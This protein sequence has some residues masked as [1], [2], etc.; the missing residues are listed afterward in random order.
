MFPP[1]I[2][3]VPPPS[4]VPGTL[5]LLT[6]AV[7]SSY[8]WP[9]T[10]LTIRPQACLVGSTATPA[11]SEEPNEATEPDDATADATCCAKIGAK[12]EKT[13]IAESS[14]TAHE[15]PDMRSTLLVPY[16]GI[17][18]GKHWLPFYRNNCKNAPVLIPSSFSPKTGVLHVRNR[19]LNKYIRTRSPSALPSRRLCV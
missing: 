3:H 7:V 2:V 15:L 19:G 17:D 8:V 12:Y 1:K 6:T 11:P 5:L 13:R 14:G 16:T 18:V 4:V 10:T 9:N